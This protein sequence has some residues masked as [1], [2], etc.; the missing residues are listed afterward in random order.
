MILLLSNTQ[1]TVY[2]YSQFTLLLLGGI[3]LRPIGQSLETLPPVVYPTKAFDMTGVAL[4]VYT[5]I[6][7][8]YHHAPILAKIRA[9]QAAAVGAGPAH[10][11]KGRRAVYT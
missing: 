6:N 8:H 10:P 2:A 7:T 3:G 5:A 4:R 9:M 11:L 1:C